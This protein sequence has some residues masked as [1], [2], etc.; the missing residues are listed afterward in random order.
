MNLF[1]RAFLYVTRKI[2]KT[3]LLFLILLVIS[4]LVLSGVAIKEATGTAAL[5][6][7][8][9]LGGIFTLQQ[10]TRDPSKWV[11]TSVG[12]I[13][14]QSYY[15]GEPLTV[16]LA[17]RIMTGTEGISGYNATYT[18][19][20]VPLNADGKILELIDSDDNGN[21]LGSLMVGHGDFNST[22]STIAATNTA[23]DSYF[24]GGYIELVEGQHFRTES[25]NPVI[26]SAELAELNS[27]SVGD[28][29]TLRMSEYKASMM[30]IDVGKT[31]VEVTIVGLFRSTAKSMTSLSNWSMDNSIFTTLEVVKS[32]RPDMGD[33]SF[34][35][36]QFYVNDPREIDRIVQ[37]VKNLPDLDPTDFI[38]SV[39]SSN[40]D[41]VMEPLT[42]MDRLVSILIVLVLAVGTVILCLVLSI[43]VK[44]RVHESG[45]QL[46][47]GLCKGNIVAQYLAEVLI[48]A[49][50]AFSLSA[51]T[52][53]IV[54]KTVGN[55]LLD[56]TISDRIQTISSG[57]PGT[58]FDGET[59]L[60]S[61]DFAPEFEGSNPLTKIEVEVESVMVAGMFGVGLLIICAAV[62]LAA[63]PVL[64]M[65][66]REILSKMS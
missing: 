17:E 4:T 12:S 16:D 64:R 52:S 66:P 47:L 49:A 15:G 7:R 3:F 1:H 11:S 8:Q 9:A 31:K 43:R 65:K 2:T 41:A 25:E 40:V 38:V 27:L 33:E 60:G 59:F 45:V 30:G 54:A 37:D 53:G 51:F 36:I 22:V 57:T 50:V 58:N 32:A 55:Q 20:T 28:K 18:N 5:N 56:Y 29:I 23:Y 10:N 21:D 14:S 13:G 19:Y 6:V 46:A 39:D 48:I 44:E 34:E 35:R 62:M 26:I 24:A 61:S 42:N 63:A